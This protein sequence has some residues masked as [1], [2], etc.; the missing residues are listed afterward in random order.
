MKIKGGCTVC[1]RDFPADLVTAQ[2]HAGHC[3]FC[4]VALDAHYSGNFVNA[5]A[6]VQRSG[7]ALE[8]ALDQLGRLGPGFELDAN[9][10]LDPLRGA[11]AQRGKAGEPRAS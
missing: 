9:S 7:S 6:A 8:A 2:E 1:G 10:V 3:P 4:G 11:L 5:L